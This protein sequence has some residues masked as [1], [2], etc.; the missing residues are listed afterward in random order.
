MSLCHCSR[1][2]FLYVLF[3]FGPGTHFAGVL[4]R[5]GFLYDGLLYAIA[6]STTDVVHELIED[7]R[8]ALLYQFQENLLAPHIGIESNHDDELKEITDRELP[9]VQ[10]GSQ[11]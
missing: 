1:L 11:P 4:L 2:L 5:H 9:I 6:S 3:N 8:I 7:F 10:I